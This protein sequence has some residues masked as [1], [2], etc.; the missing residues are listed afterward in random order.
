MLRLCLRLRIRQLSSQHDPTKRN[1]TL[2][3][4][5]QE[6]IDEGQGFLV[7]E[8][9]RFV[10][11]MK[12]S[13]DPIPFSEPL[14]EQERDRFWSKVAIRCN[15]QCWI[16]ESYRNRAGYGVFGFRRKSRLAPRIAFLDRNGSVPKNLCVLHTCDNPACVNPKHLWLGTRRD[17]NLDCR[18][19]G[20]QVCLSGENH[21]RKLRPE[22][23]P[24]GEKAGCAKL[25]TRQVIKIRKTY[26]R[27]KISQQKLADRYGVSRGLI[28]HIV[29]GRS[30]R[31]LLWV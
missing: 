28:G 29:R 18:K 30:W 11:T 13:S 26:V 17:N 16:W 2:S 5:Y 31:H 21:P 8:D 14:T 20:R 7:E 10:P 19:K 22:L 15:S 25:K 23:F 3:Y 27:G 4:P 9:S 1:G 12:T 6:K 24:I